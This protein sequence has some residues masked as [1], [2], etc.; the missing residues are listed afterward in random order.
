[1]VHEQEYRKCYGF[2]KGKVIKHLQYGKCKI[3]IPSIHHDDWEKTP[4]KLPDAYPAVPV[5]GGAYK[6]NGMFSYPNV[7]AIVW[8][9]FEN[10]DQNFPQYFAGTLEGEDAHEHWD[11]IGPNIPADGDSNI[12]KFVT[13][14]CSIEYNQDGKITID[15]WSRTSPDCEAKICISKYG[16]ISLN[17]TKCIK[18]DA[19]NIV[20]NAQESM[21]INTPSFIN[22]NAVKN[23]VVCPSIDL[24]AST[25]MVNI[26]SVLSPTGSPII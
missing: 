2:Y 12:H 16:H 20:I 21:T 10:G 9:F 8:V 13:G 19:P 7:N 5:F 11:Q 17:S 18:L 6:G 1:M 23:V 22:M 15:V 14:Q 4:D 3:W 26:K 24:D 25:G